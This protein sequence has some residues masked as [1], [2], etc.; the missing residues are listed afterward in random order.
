MKYNKKGVL[1]FAIVFA[2]ALL[3]LV[4]VF[5]EEAYAIQLCSNCYLNG[6]HMCL[7]SL[8][9]CDDG[10]TTRYCDQ[11]LTGCSVPCGQ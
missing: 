3:G 2:V 7:H 5:H 6:G 10:I 11:D 8:C 9:K 1:L 4:Q